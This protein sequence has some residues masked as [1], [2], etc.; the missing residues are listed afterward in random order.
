MTLDHLYAL[1]ACI[2]SVAIHDEGDVV[3]DWARFEHAEEGTSDTVDGIVPKPESVLQKRHCGGVG[4]RGTFT[5]TDRVPWL[6]EAF[7]LRS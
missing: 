3:R 1:V 5:A 7:L 4:G 6:M 2:A